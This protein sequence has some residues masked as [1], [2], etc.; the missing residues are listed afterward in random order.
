MT[1]EELL[2]RIKTDFVTIKHASELTGVSAIHLRRII[3]GGTKTWKPSVQLNAVKVGQKWYI[4]KSSL[5]D[6]FL[7]GIQL[8][9]FDNSDISGGDNANVGEQAT[10]SSGDNGLVDLL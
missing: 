5:A 4:E 2:N 3:N 8:P 9:L 7:K 1:N 6:A 10:K